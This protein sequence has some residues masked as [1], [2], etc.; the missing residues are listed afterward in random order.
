MAD[1]NGYDIGLVDFTSVNGGSL[2]PE[3]DGTYVTPQPDWPSVG[4]GN[5]PLEMADG[6]YTTPQPDWPSVNGGSLPNSFAGTLIPGPN[7][8]VRYVMRAFKTLA[9]TGHIY[10]ESFDEPDPTGQESNFPQNYLTDIVVV[11]ILSEVTG[12]HV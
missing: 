11:S 4:G 2:P 1:F 6:T 9:P 7:G 8:G 5:V 3:L 10:W 12:E